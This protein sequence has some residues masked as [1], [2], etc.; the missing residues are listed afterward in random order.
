MVRG[1][2]AR[3]AGLKIHLLG[4]LGRRIAAWR[5]FVLRLCARLAEEKRLGAACVQIGVVSLPLRQPAVGELVDLAGCAAVGARD[6]RPLLYALQRVECLFAANRACAVLD[7]PL[8]LV[9]VVLSDQRLALVGQSPVVTPLL[10]YQLLIKQTVERPF[11]L[12]LV[13]FA[14]RELPAA[15]ACNLRDR[16]R[17]W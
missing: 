16:A 15:G 2:S 9:V 5:R 7:R 8:G 12:A 11:D 17:L 3:S 10:F 6:G 14:V 4:V 13:R 1:W